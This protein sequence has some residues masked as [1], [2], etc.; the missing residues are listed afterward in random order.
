MGAKLD[1]YIEALDRLVKGDT[2]PDVPQPLPDLVDLDPEDLEAASSLLAETEEIIA[3]IE[4]RMASI[5]ESLRKVPPVQRRDSA[6]VF[7]KRA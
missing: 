5:R 4:S 7:D 3:I 1:E 6:S 2:Q